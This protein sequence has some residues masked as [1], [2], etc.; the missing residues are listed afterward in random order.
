[1]I[2]HP[3]ARIGQDGF[4]FVPGPDGHL[5][6]PQV[7]RVV[8]QDDVEIGANS[9]IDRGSIRDT[10]IGEGTKIDNL[11]QVGHNVS[12][13][14]H[15]LLAGTVGIAGSVTLGDF[16]ALGGNVGVAP[17]I[18]IGAGASVAAK[19]GVFNDIPPGER[20][21]GY[22]ARPA[23][24]WMRA[25]AAMRRAVRSKASTPKNGGKKLSASGSRTGRKAP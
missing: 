8:I 17:H 1:M 2:I 13:G 19:S 24:E 22:P 12:V 10:I 15:C 25:Q 11:V 5:K 3:G 18:T 6:V 20:W 14:R 9:A 7:G 21:G 23:D 16:V 4:G